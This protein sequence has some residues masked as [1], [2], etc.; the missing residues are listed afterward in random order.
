MGIAGGTYG[1]GHFDSSVNLH[2]RNEI[3]CHHRHHPTKL[4]GPRHKVQP[5]LGPT[6]SAKVILK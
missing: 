6:P 2:S 3:V 4:Q 1:P 5:N